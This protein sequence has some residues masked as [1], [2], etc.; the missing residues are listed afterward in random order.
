M[1]VQVDPKLRAVTIKCEHCGKKAVRYVTSNNMQLPKFCSEAHKRRSSTKRWRNRVGP[2][3]DHKRCTEDPRAKVFRNNSR[4]WRYARRAGEALGN[5]EP[6]LCECG[7]LH[8]RRI[9]EVRR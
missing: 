9:P 6:Y 7:G 2:A 4:G 3:I 5:R 8:L 1:T